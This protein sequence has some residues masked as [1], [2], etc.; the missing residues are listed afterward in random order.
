MSLDEVRLILKKETIEELETLA[1]AAGELRAIIAAAAEIAPQ[2]GTPPVAR[3]IARKLGK[4]IWELRS[5]LAAVLN[6]YRTSVNL[7]LNVADTAE[8]V[9]RALRHAAKTDE[10]EARIKI[11]ESAK[12]RIVQ[13]AGQLQPDH[14]L[15]SAQKALRVAASRQYELVDMR[16][17]TD[18]RPVFNEAGDAILQMI[19]THVLSLDYHSGHD[20]RVIQFTLD[21]ADLAELT[22]LCERAARK[23]AVVKRDLKVASWPTA[24]FREPVKPDDSDE[25]E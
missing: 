9:S 20:H 4:P 5:I 3:L 8:A 10:D 18:A 2:I 23:A 25:Q 15:V 21:A 7:E 19:I 13:A 12:D 14:P 6:F 17:F 24:I 22:K 11:W 1:R 16:I